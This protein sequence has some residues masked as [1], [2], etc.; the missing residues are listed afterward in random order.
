MRTLCVAGWGF[1]AGAEVQSFA[2]CWAQAGRLIALD[3]VPSAHW[4]MAILDARRQTPAWATFCA[5]K[6][7]HLPQAVELWCTDADI[8]G[9]DTALQSMRVAQRFGT[10]SVAEA[11]ALHGV[12]RA[13]S[14]TDARLLMPRVVSLDRRATLAIATFQ[15]SS[16]SI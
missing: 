11:L 8:R 1:R 10:G 16:F 7:A 9:I 4:T 13:A 15:S 2:D 6:Y 12:A 5:W 14:S 3:G